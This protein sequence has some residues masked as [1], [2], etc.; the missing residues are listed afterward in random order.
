MLLCLLDFEFVSHKVETSSLFRAVIVLVLEF[1]ESM[2]CAFI[3]L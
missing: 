2:R 1:K 3:C